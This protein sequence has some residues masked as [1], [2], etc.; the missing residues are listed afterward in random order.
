MD[1]NVDIRSMD[2]SKEHFL[3]AQSVLKEQIDAVRSKID[4]LRVK[5][6]G[7]VF[8]Q[9]TRFVNPYEELKFR[10]SSSRAFFKL[11]EI[12][13][14]YGLLERHSQCD[15][16][17]TLHLC[18]APGSF[19]E[20]TQEYI[21]R[22]FPKSRLDWY[23]VTLPDGLEWKMSAQSSSNVIYADVIKD[24]L[25]PCV[26]Q[27]MLVTGDGGFE[28]DFKDRNNQE[29]QNTPL[30]AGQ[31]HQSFK[32]LAPNG[33]MVIK[34]FD[35][36]EHDTCDLLWDCYLHFDKLYI[37]KPFGSRICNSEKYIVGIRY[38]P[39][40]Q[41]IRSGIN[42]IIPEWFYGRIWTINAQF[43]NVQVQ[44]LLQSIRLTE[45]SSPKDWEKSSDKKHELTQRCLNWFG[46][47]K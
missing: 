11:Y 2:L 28:I 32:T 26:Q 44:S 16:F 23:G 10:G 38:N 39:K 45:T 20:A 9:A 8:T 27:S 46:L 31:I 37:I 40:Y 25:P 6:L 17:K 3:E 18:E 5:G 42:S 30:L 19:V 13:K 14:R 41:G 36:M 21:K 24:K 33:N 47:D 43:V 34:M 29:V 1:F 4:V 15:C 7:Y 22:H 12:F 35:M